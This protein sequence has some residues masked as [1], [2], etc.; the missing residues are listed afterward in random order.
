MNGNIP[1]G[2]QDDGEEGLDPGLMQLFDAAKRD[3]LMAPHKRAP[4]AAPA[5]ASGDA[6]VAA[7]VLRMQQTRRLRLIRQITGLALILVLTALL[8]PYVA[9]QTFLI[10]DWFT[11]QLPATGMALL[12]SIGCLCGALFAWSVSRWAR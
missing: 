8:A 4:L 5:P 11:N 3:A 12:S 9:T 6:F 7:V 10:A 2:P 1:Q